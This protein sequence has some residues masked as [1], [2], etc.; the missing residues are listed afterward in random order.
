MKRYLLILSA[1]FLFT[2]SLQAQYIY[3]MRPGPRYRP[4]PRHQNLP[5]FDPEVYLKVGYGFPNLDKNDLLW[6][7][8]YYTGTAKQNGPISASI[9]YR[10]KRSSSVG[11]MV[12]YGKLNAPYYSFNSNASAPPSFYGHLESWSVMLNLVRYIPVATD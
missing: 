9:D 6:F 2:I 8:N 1:I 3:R 11:L 10:F 12:M 7:N 5:K 4:A